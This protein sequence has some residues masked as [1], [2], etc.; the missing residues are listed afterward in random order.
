MSPVFVTFSAADMQ[1]QDLHRHFPGLSPDLRLDE[2]AGRRF[3]WDRVSLSLPTTST[4][5]SGRRADLVMYTV[6]SGYRLPLP[7]TTKQR[8]PELS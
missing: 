5:S 3:V 7:W 4:A 1:W 8:S 2:P 6:S